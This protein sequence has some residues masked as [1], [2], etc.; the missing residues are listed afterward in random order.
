YEIAFIDKDDEYHGPVGKLVNSQA[1]AIKAIDAYKN[2]GYNQIKIYSSIDTSWVRAMC[3]EAHRLNMRV[4]GHIPYHL[5]AGKAVLDGYDEITHMNMVMFNFFPDTVDTRK[6]RFKPIGRFANT[7]DMNGNAVKD[8]VS[9][10][11]E[12]HTVVEPSQKHGGKA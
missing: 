6:N 12:K 9:L 1:E 2:S 10:L 4:A 3:T 5:T 11:Q 8:F 7:I